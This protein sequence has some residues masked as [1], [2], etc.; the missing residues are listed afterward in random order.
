MATKNYGRRQDLKLLSIVVFVKLGE[1]SQNYFY[2]VITVKIQ[3]NNKTQES[4]ST[5]IFL[6]STSISYY[7]KNDPVIVFLSRIQKAISVTISSFGNNNETK[8]NPQQHK[9]YST[10]RNE[11]IGGRKKL[12]H[13]SNI[14]FT[15]SKH[16]QYLINYS[17]YIF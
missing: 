5:E 6:Q 9:E 1:R 2:K 8:D 3:R 7:Y 16:K 17:E 4:I 11:K 13:L 15:S 12:S 10:K 14:R